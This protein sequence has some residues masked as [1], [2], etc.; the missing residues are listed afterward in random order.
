M[1]TQIDTKFQEES[2]DAIGNILSLMDDDWEKKKV[3]TISQIK[4]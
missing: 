3:K 1:T 4:L 2:N